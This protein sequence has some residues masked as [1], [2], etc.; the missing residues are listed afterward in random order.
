V[1]PA[2]ERSRLRAVAR[3][4]HERWGREFL[5]AAEQWVSK[6]PW[7]PRRNRPWYHGRYRRWYHA[8]SRTG[9]KW[10]VRFRF[11]PVV[12]SHDWNRPEI[13]LMIGAQRA[14]TI[15]VH[16][17]PFREEHGEAAVRQWEHHS[18][19]RSRIA[20]QLRRSVPP[21]VDDLT[22]R[23]DGV[24]MRVAAGV[25]RTT[26]TGSSPRGARPR[27]TATISSGG[28]RREGRRPP[29]AAAATSWKRR[30]RGDGRRSSRGSS[31]TTRARGS[32][33]GSAGRRRGR[34]GR[35]AR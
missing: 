28:A 24:A 34:C 33:T 14:F 35:P 30:S 6:S 1:S 11:E 9:A 20:P 10:S 12:E 2:C 17:K 22:R 32:R 29:T 31:S 21:A 23:P 15:D 25:G 16:T 27:S 26:T 18:N 13:A 3:V 5:D 7:S 4:G 8:N 19:A